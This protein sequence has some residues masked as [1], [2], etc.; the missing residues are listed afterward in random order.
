MNLPTNFTNSALPGKGSLRAVVVLLGLT[1]LA[2][3]FAAEDLPVLD[4]NQTLRPFFGGSWE[5]DF[6]LSDDWEQQLNQTIAQL[7]RAAELQRRQASSDRGSSRRPAINIGGQNPSRRGGSSIVDLARLAELVTRQSTLRI[8]QTKNEIRIEREG[9]AALIC[10]IEANF[11]ETFSSKYGTE[12]C[13][14]EDRQLIFQISLPEGVTILHR[15]TVSSNTQL[16]NMVTRISSGRSTPFNLIQ[17]FRRYDA[18]LDDFN[19]VQTLSRGIV[20]SKTESQ[21]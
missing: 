8:V 12:Y 9:D 1:C 14:W 15:F 13:A 11:M 16:L 20:C 18:P 19:C 4:L 10:G 21:N 5:K 3:A 2:V 17:V 7:Q 6:R